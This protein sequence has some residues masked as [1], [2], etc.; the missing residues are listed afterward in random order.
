MREKLNIIKQIFNKIPKFLRGKCKNN[1]YIHKEN[2]R[3]LQI[4]ESS[5]ENKLYSEI[6]KSIFSHDFQNSR[7]SECTNHLFLQSRIRNIENQKKVSREH[8]ILFF[9]FIHI[10]IYIKSISL[11]PKVMSSCMVVISFHVYFLFYIFYFFL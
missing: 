6:Y 7:Y 5:R 10:Y 2:R 11:S 9:M 4:F 8:V 1:R 3:I